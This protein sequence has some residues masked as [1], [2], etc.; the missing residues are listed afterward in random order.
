MRRVAVIHTFDRYHASGGVERRGSGMNAGRG[1]ERGGVRGSK[2]SDIVD[3]DQQ[4]GI[5]RTPSTAFL[6]DGRRVFR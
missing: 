2:G 6:G 3:A 4:E 1:R 5:Q